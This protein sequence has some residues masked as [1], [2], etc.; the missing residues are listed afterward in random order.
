MCEALPSCGT[1]YRPPRASRL[2][3]WRTFPEVSEALRKEVGFTEH[4]RRGSYRTMQGRFTGPKL[5]ATATATMLMRPFYSGRSLSGGEEKT[6]F[7]AGKVPTELLRVN[8]S[9]A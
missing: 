7:R 5:T 4:P 8:A 9:H 6:I 1:R 2:I 3:G